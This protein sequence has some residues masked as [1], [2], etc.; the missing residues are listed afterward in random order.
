MNPSRKRQTVIRTLPRGF[1]LWSEALQRQWL[2]QLGLA[3][4]IRPGKRRKG[5]RPDKVSP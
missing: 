4:L 2:A 3:G 1:G 5:G